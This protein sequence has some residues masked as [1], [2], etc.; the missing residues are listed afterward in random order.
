MTRLFTQKHFMVVWSFVKLESNS[1]KLFFK[2]GFLLGIFFIVRRDKF[3]LLKQITTT[4]LRSILMSKLLN[5]TFKATQNASVVGLIR[6]CAII[7][8]LKSIM[9]FVQPYSATGK[10]SFTIQLKIIR[11]K[12]PTFSTRCHKRTSDYLN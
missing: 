7:L 9:L 11:V 5:I 2:F 3:E 6:H 8:G 1:Q 4:K 10:Q 12:L